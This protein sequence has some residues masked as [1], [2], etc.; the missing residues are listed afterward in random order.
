MTYQF[1]HVF[2]FY[3][4]Q[5]RLAYAYNRIDLGDIYDRQATVYFKLSIDLCNADS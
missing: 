5:K 4:W 1:S 3:S 2:T